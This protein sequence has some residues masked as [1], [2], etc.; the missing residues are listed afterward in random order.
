MSFVTA[1]TPYPASN[2][3][4]AEEAWDLDD[5][6]ISLIGKTD[7]TVG[8]GCVYNTS[9]I[10]PG[11]KSLTCDNGATGFFDSNWQNMSLGQAK[12]FSF[13]IQG[14]ILDSLYAFGASDAATEQF[15]L[16]G[17]A[18]GADMGVYVYDGASDWQ[19]QIPDLTNVNSFT[20]ITIVKEAGLEYTSTKIYINE[21]YY[22]STNN[23]SGPVSNDAVDADFYWF[24]RNNNGATA[25]SMTANMQEILIFPYALSASEVTTLHTGNFS[26]TSQNLNIS[27]SLPLDNTQYA[28]SNID[29]NL[30]VNST[31]NFNCSLYFSGVLNKTGTYTLGQNVFVNFTIPMTTGNYTYKFSCY[32]A[33]AFNQDNVNTTESL[34]FVDTVL[35]IISTDFK[36]GSIVTNY[37]NGT[38]NFAD[39]NSL[40]SFNISIDGSQIAYTDNI[41]NAS[42]EYLLGYNLENITEGTHSLEVTVADGHTAK[43]LAGDYEVNNGLFNDYIEFGL[44]N[45]KKVKIENKFASLFDDW[46]AT[47]EKDRYSFKYKP[48]EKKETQTFRVLA[49]G[50][51]D[52]MDVPNSKYKK[53][54][55]VDKSHW[56]DFY[57][58]KDI[59]FVMLSEKEVEVTIRGIDVNAEDITFN[60]IGDLNIVTKEYSFYKTGLTVA[61]SSS[62]AEKQDQD[63]TLRINKNANVNSTSAIFTYNITTYAT[64]K[65]TFP[66]Y[67]LYTASFTTPEISGDTALF[68]FTWDYTILG[69]NNTNNG[70]ITNTQTV[71]KILI[72]NC[73]VFTTEALGLD[74]RSKNNGS[75]VNGNIAGYFRV[76]VDEEDSFR[77]FNLTWGGGSEYGIC[78]SPKET[79]YTAYGQLEYSAPGWDERTY[80]FNNVSLNNV[81]ETVNLYLTNETSLV[82]FTVLDQDDT[83][84]PNVLIKVLTYD[85]GTDSAEVV[86]I[87]KT[88]NDGK[89]IGNIVLNTQWYKFILEQDGKI[90]FV[91][92]PVKITS[93]QKTFRIN[94]QT[95]YFND[96]GS[97]K[98]TIGDVYFTNASRTFTY[99]FSESTGAGV[100]ACL[101]VKKRILAGDTVMVNNC[102]TSAAGTIHYTIVENVSSNMYIGTGYIVVEGMEYVI[103]VAT[104]SF[105]ER[106]KDW[107]L[108][109]IFVT[110]MIVLTLVM[111]GVSSNNPSVAVGLM[112]IGFIGSIMM[113]IFFLNW[114]VLMVFIIIG[115]LVMYKLSR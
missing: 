100:T 33:T 68:D 6:A 47:K 79:T 80:Y 70:E 62:I 39:E 19:I 45:G 51:I 25:N 3:L 103:D 26:T 67:D 105:N 109:G 114:Q 91:S 86:E 102:T 113:T 101:E 36:T 77:E 21:T 58:Y 11:K 8:A 37:I 40:F 81:S 17:L 42:Y 111:V 94:T 66:T 52:I 59:T 93:T 112:M 55:V 96:Y 9:T 20:R 27:S 110:F 5:D 83:D 29:Y 10:F 69:I 85:T 97:A 35:P 74:I 15:G 60:S 30:S 89:A 56:L 75:L 46:S 92:D 72:D 73:S 90:L 61:Y 28:Y 38:F 2:P 13:M 44:Y 76:W 53:W 104:V 43:E 7:G 12:T 34:I 41:L 63:I 31:E 24:A 49:E 57:P 98:N 22:A 1:L 84:V 78:F 107:G 50:T 106:Y 18:G 4:G 14:D 71:T 16:W 108:E 115:G 48:N 54:L 88:D 82:E 99:T 64:T 65:Q 32:N 87:I 23:N 95:N